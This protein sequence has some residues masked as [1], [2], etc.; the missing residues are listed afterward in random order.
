MP[1]KGRGPPVNVR[2]QHRNLANGPVHNCE[3]KSARG[4][5]CA[6]AERHGDNELVA[7]L[8]CARSTLGATLGPT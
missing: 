2:E 8:E 4:A 1:A 5:S 7:G 3:E 6:R